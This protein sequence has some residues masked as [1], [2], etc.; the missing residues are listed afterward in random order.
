MGK[1][2]TKIN[3]INIDKL[4]KLIGYINHRVIV[5]N[6][7]SPPEAIYLANELIRYYKWE[8]KQLER[9]HEKEVE[10]AV[11]WEDMKKKHKAIVSKMVT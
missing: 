1:T 8:M 7:L 9:E 5:K 4:E 6:E 2:T 3:L 10:E 11:Y